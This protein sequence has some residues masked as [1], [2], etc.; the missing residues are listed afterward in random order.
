MTEANLCG[1]VERFQGS[2]AWHGAVN[3]HIGRKDYPQNANNC[4]KVLNKNTLLS[5]VDDY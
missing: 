1:P 4:L 3:L 2:I 5:F